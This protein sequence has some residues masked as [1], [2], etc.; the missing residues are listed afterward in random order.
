MNKNS[1]LLA[2]I[3]VEEIK[4]EFAIKHLSKNLMDT[5]KVIGEGNDVRIEIPART[6][7]ML[8]FQEEGV[9]VYTS[10]GSYASKLDE[11]GSQFNAYRGGQG[12]TGQVRVSPGNHKGYIDS[13]ISKSLQRFAAESGNKINKI[14]DTNGH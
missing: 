10:H 12:R 3:I 9:I 8:K 2:R 1:E 5:I 13:V 7:N 11:R 6:Y 14:E 4:N